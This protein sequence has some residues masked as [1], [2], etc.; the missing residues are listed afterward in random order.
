MHNINITEKNPFQSKDN[1][2]QWQ[3]QEQNKTKSEQRGLG[4]LYVKRFGYD[5]YCSNISSKQNVS[6]EF[7][8]LKRLKA[9]YK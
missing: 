2:L 7:L 3:K 4:F 1:D 6:A 8:L 5:N 9:F